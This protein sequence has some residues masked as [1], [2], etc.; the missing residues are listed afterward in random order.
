MLN[1]PDAAAQVPVRRAPHF[2][3][4]LANVGFR[5]VRH[6]I[7]IALPGFHRQTAP[8]SEAT[9]MSRTPRIDAA[10]PLL[11]ATHNQ[12]SGDGID[13]RGFLKCMAWAGTGLVWTFSGGVPV[14]RAFGELR[15][16][17]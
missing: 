4:L 17:T 13:R 1:L 7:K 8:V 12:V 11:D 15:T 5:A 3:R 6:G 14:S 9:A 10:E 16:C 2:R